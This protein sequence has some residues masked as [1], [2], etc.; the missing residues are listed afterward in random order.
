MQDDLKDVHKRLQQKKRPII[1]EHT[2][3]AMV[4][5]SPV[6]KGVQSS[7]GTKRSMDMFGNH[8]QGTAVDLVTCPLCHHRKAAGKFAIHLE[9]CMGLGRQAGRA[10]TRRISDTLNSL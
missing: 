9:K 3:A 5:T 7:G 10:A 6:T 2:D 4:I 1:R 8:I